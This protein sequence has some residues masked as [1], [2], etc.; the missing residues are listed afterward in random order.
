MNSPLPAY[1]EA[2]S[3]K[4]E[5]ALAR[6]GDK[7]T[8]ET[9]FMIPSDRIAPDV[10]IDASGKIIQGCLFRLLGNSFSCN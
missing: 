10:V 6:F 1:P 9:R 3:Y 4:V 7:S 2:R 5:I 8:M